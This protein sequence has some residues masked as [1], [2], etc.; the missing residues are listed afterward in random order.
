[1]DTSE[2]KPKESVLES[3]EDMK[4]VSQTTTFFFFAHSFL[5]FTQEIEER[6]KELGRVKAELDKLKREKAAILK[7]NKELAE[8]NEILRLQIT[9]LLRKFRVN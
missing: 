8:D 7:L 2:H 9:F 4:K 3:P 5:A 6:D 1:M